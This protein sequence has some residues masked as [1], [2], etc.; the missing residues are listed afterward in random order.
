ME[1]IACEAVRLALQGGATD[2][3]CSLVQGHEFSVNVRHGQVENLKEA[4][5]RATGIRVLAGQRTGSAYTSD[6]TRDGIRAMVQGAVEIANITNDDPYAGL[7][8]HSEFGRLETDLE[9]YFDDVEAL[10]TAEKIRLARDAETAALSVDPRIN[11]SEG[12][13]FDSYTGMRVFANSRGFV[14]SYRTSSC[15][16]AAVPVAREGDR[17]ERDSWT[18]AARSSTRLETPEY[19]GRKAAERV[20][21][22]LGPRKVPTQKAPV[23][24]ESRAARSL[25][26]HLFD[27]VNGASVYRKASFLAGQLGRQI[28]ASNVTIVDDATMPRLFGSSPCDDEGV[29]SRC[30]VVVENGILSSYLLNTYTARRLG[31]K[32]TGNASRGLTGAA[33]VGH[34][35]LYLEPGQSSAEEI[36]RG[37]GKGLYV[38]ELIGFGVNTVTGDYSRGAVGMWIENGALSFPVSEVTIASTLQQM[39]MGLAVIGSDLE[40]RGSLA[41]PTLL[42]SEMMISGQ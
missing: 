21:R 6:L 23:V 39:L 31:M 36:I 37:I 41:S 1:E 8:E 28:A 18:T 14:H 35:N 7:P 12:A 26:S 13:S 5:S 4:G 40:F 32:T 38:T 19:V 33:S 30:T 3:E 42:V 20:L 22:R 15:A 9:L 11:N 27:A 34:G 24:F 16:L 2:A 29:P 10:S 25:L 17:M